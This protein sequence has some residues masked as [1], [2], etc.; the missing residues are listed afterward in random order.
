MKLLN[1]GKKSTLK[2]VLLLATISLGTVGFSAWVINGST[3]DNQDITFSVGN[4]IDKTLTVSI[5]DSETDGTVAFDSDGTEGNG[6]ITGDGGHEDLTFEVVYTVTSVNGFSADSPVKVT[7]TYSGDFEGIRG[8]ATSNYINADCLKV[9]NITLNGTNTTPNEGVSVQYSG[10]SATVTH[11]WTFAWGSVFKGKNPCKV[12][13]GD[14]E[15]YTNLITNLKNFETAAKAAMTGNKT[16][17][18]T[19]TPSF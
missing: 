11:T 3:P 9:T 16:F 5:D 14:G 6:L 12:A 13:V 18:I 1:K 7:Y 4:V 15:A 17:N 2:G 10:S 19:I 8:F